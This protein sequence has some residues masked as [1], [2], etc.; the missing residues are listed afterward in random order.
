MSISQ[1]ECHSLTLVSVGYHPGITP[2]SPEYCLDIRRKVPAGGFLGALN[3]VSEEVMIVTGVCVSVTALRSM[4]LVLS[5][6]VN[7]CL[8]EGNVGDIQCPKR[9]V[10]I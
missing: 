9:K 5:F 7:G 1:D 10:E 2:E 3:S 6:E 8:C 4:M